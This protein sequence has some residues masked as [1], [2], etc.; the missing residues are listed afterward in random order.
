MWVSSNS[1]NNVFN[2]QLLKEGENVFL[3]SCQTTA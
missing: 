1:T 2:T 3:P